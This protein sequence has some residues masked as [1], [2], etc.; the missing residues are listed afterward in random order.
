MYLEINTIKYNA[1]REIM[2]INENLQ[3]VYIRST[4]NIYWFMGIRIHC[5]QI[6]MNSYSVTFDYS[7]YSV[8]YL[9]SSN[10]GNL[11]LFGPT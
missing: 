6:P 11:K 3:I 8:S 5:Q 1:D 7:Y 10:E 2:N 9:M 4:S